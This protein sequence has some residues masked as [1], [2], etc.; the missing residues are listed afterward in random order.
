MKSKFSK[1]TSTLILII[2]SITVLIIPALTITYAETRTISHILDVQAVYT[3]GTY[4]QT[5]ALNQTIITEIYDIETLIGESITNDTGYWG[6]AT[7]GIDR[8]SIYWA[9]FQTYLGNGTYEIN[10]N[11][12]LVPASDYTSREL[13]IQL[14]INN[15]EWL[16]HDFIKV[17]SNY[18]GNF[19]C[20]FA[21]ENGLF[22]PQSPIK[23]TTDEYIFINT[24]SFRNALQS[25][26]DGIIIIEF[27]LQNPDI[28][29]IFDFQITAFDLNAVDAFTWDDSQVYVL[30]LLGCDMILIIGFVFTTNFI[31]IAVDKSKPRKPRTNRR[32][33]KR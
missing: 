32:Y 16:S 24:F 1:T 13:I 14:D 9:D 6:Y 22:V 4:I 28:E 25:Y 26:P 29:S 21:T 12:S 17:Y 2:I 10:A 7:T 31:D 27:D 30:T 3:N 19:R 15:S 18:T 33:R 8:S 5:D 20:Y 23:L 11:Y